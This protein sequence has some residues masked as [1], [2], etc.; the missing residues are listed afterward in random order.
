MKKEGRTLEITRR[1]FIQATTLSAL[2]IVCSSGLE[3]L[4]S[5]GRIYAAETSGTLTQYCSTPL[6]FMNPVVA[7]FNKDY[8]NIKVNLERNDTYVLYQKIVTEA[9]AGRINADVTGLTDFN[10]IRDLGKKGILA[11]NYPP[12]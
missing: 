12:P 6:V 4:F 3:T 11:E 5:G 7:I 8:P 1:G 9:S 10:I 2:G